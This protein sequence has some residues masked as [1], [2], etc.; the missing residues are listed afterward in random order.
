MYLDIYTGSAM[1][2]GFSQQLWEIMF[3]AVE[4]ALPLPPPQKML[5][6]FRK[7]RILAYEHLRD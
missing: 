5:Y 7:F 3:L 4:Y 6:K 2:T 1:K